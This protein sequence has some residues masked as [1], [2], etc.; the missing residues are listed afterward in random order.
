MKLNR[1]QV[2]LRFELFILLLFTV[3]FSGVL[4]A[5]AE[6]YEY[7]RQVGSI[8]GDQFDMPE[9]VEVDHQ[10]NFYVVDTWNHRIQKFDADG[11]LINMWGRNNGDGTSGSGDGEFFSPN[12]IAI[13]VR[14]NRAFVADTRN[15]RVQVFDL[16][17]NHI[18]NIDGAG[19][20]LFGL[21]PD[22]PPYFSNM[23]GP[24]AVAVDPRF[25][26]LYVA[27]SFER[28]Y[29]LVDSTTGVVTLYSIYHPGV[30]VYQTNGAVTSLLNLEGWD[31]KNEANKREVHSI[32]VD[33]QSRVFLANT[34]AS[35]VEIRSML[36]TKINEF[37]VLGCEPGQFN[38]D[39]GIAVDN[40]GQVYVADKFNHRIH[41][42]DSSAACELITLIGSK[43]VTTGKFITPAGV[44]VDYLGRVYV[45]DTGNNRVQVF[46][47]G[48]I[49]FANSSSQYTTDQINQISLTNLHAREFRVLNSGDPVYSAWQDV[50]GSLT[51]D[52][53]AGEGL[54]T[55]LVQVRDIWG[56]METQPYTASI[57]LDTVNPTGSINI[58]STKSVGA[59]KVSTSRNVNL[60]LSA[61]DGYSGI[62]KMRFSNDLTGPWSDWENYSTSKKWTLSLGEGIK[63]VYAQYKDVAGNVSP[64][65]SVNIW[66]DGVAPNASLTINNKTL[67]QYST[68]FT[69]NRQVNLN[70]TATDNLSLPG[71]LQYRYSEIS[72]LSTSFLDYASPNSSLV[73]SDSD[74]VKTVWVEVTDEAGNVKKVYNKVILDRQG[75]AGGVK[76]SSGLLSRYTK[77]RDIVLDFSGIKD[78]LSGV[79]DMRF[80]GNGSVW[81]D[82]ESFKYLKNWT[83][84][85]GDGDKTVYCRFRD[86][87]GNV[88]TVAKLV[89][90]D[91]VAPKPSYISSPALSSYESA[92]GYGFTVKW[93]AQDASSGIATYDVQ[94]KINTGPWQNWV[95]MIGTTKGLAKYS[96]TAG[97]TYYFR[98][99]A[100]DKSGNISGWSA[101]TKTVVPLD[102][103]VLNYTAGWNTSSGVFNDY[104]QATARMSK[105]PNA[106]AAYVVQGK[107]VYLIG[108]TA[109]YAGIANIYINGSLIAKVDLYS[110]V[111]KRNTVVFTKLFATSANRTIK[112]VVSGAKNAKSGGAWVDIDGI[113]VL[114]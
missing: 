81:T 1:R 8:T 111:T 73:L 109:P 10:G 99:R 65:Y 24:L 61:T 34:V 21:D 3:F 46:R 64:S 12:D 40:L 38:W 60:V 94:V 20:Y 106:Y 83:L 17:G 77:K 102:D 37:G 52:L 82:W 48:S 31:V 32:A 68:N 2:P 27:G 86:N 76:L 11:T 50:Q 59:A 70:L 5:N 78:S 75:P 113:G 84:S 80:S 18:S 30:E 98:F 74:G 13:N 55:I 87:A 4:S 114:K 9:N 101:A 103:K 56:N 90:L 100:K 89:T 36:G 97:N 112:V 15:N 23:I 91:T 6:E 45:A 95:G 47:T 26:R 93:K 72:P 58:N 53:G 88:R 35:K 79:S 71:N 19:N 92:S 29:K 96:N 7:L 22:I 49:S 69:R 105:L 41:V 14:T 25:D 39:S 57:K 110:P 85:A 43:G 104:F 44:A 51:W 66:F 62:E 63:T 28:M 54:K 67:A 108:S 42:Y 107:G 33:S 16:N